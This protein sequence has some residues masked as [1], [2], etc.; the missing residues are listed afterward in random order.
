MSS[1]HNVPDQARRPSGPTDILEIVCSGR[2]R[3]LQVMLYYGNS[4]MEVILTAKRKGPLGHFCL[5]A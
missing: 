3:E 2:C 4:S 1:R 5:G